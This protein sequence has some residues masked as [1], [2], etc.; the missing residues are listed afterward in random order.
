MKG[1]NNGKSCN[2]DLDVYVYL[3][4]RSLSPGCIIAKVGH[5]YESIVRDYYG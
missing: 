3:R 2:N 5:D 4:S 1:I